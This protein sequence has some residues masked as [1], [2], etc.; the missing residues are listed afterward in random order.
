MAQTC[1]GCPA[2]DHARNIIT[3]FSTGKNPYDKPWPVDAKDRKSKFPCYRLKVSIRDENDQAEPF[4]YNRE[5]G[6]P[7]DHEVRVP[8][9]AVSKFREKIPSQRG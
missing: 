5:L 8:S 1:V 6:E 7:V 3:R 9:S 4:V 2:S